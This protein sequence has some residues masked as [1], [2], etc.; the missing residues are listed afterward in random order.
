MRPTPQEGSLKLLEYYSGAAGYPESL[1]QPRRGDLL[2]ETE[3]PIEWAP[4]QV[5]S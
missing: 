1:P 3:L 2:V 4:E 5:F